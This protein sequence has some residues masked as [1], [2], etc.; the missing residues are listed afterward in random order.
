MKLKIIIK[1]LISAI[2]IVWI[3]SSFQIQNIYTSI[4]NASIFTFLMCLLYWIFSIISFNSLR[5]YLLL[6][7]KISFYKIA[8]L[9]FIAQF[10]SI[11][12]PGQVAGEISKLYIQKKGTKKIEHYGASIFID[13]ILGI[14][15]LLG[16]CIAGIISTK[17]QLPVVLL[18]ST[19]ILFFLGIFMIYFVRI[20]LIYNSILKTMLFIKAKYIFLSSLCSIIISFFESLKIYSN[21]TLI[22]LMGILLSILFQLS[23]VFIIDL[24]AK[25]MGINILF[26]DWCWIQGV[27]SLA[28]LLPLTFAGLGIREG[29]LISIL[30]ILGVAPEKALALSFS[31][32]GLQIIL[33]SI[34][35]L[36]EFKRGIL[37]FNYKN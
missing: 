36:I 7:Y 15:G 27:L 29:T 28:L 18:Y 11:I 32:L 2:L 30:G 16:V 8:Q 34:G 31:I 9:N 26:F 14:I 4:S 6:Q 5:W 23:G 33:A 35:G 21:K 12:L 17:T 19:V 20:P 1:I 25:D 22:I 10:Y 13:K 37:E 24:L 3:L